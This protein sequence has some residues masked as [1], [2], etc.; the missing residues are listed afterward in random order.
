MLNMYFKVKEQFHEPL[1]YWSAWPPKPKN[2]DVLVY[3]K[4]GSFIYIKVPT[5]NM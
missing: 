2:C 5:E 4:Q 1:D 3:L